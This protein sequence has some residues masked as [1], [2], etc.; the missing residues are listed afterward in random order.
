MIGLIYLKELMLKKPKINASAL[1]MITGIFLRL[2]S[3]RTM[4]C[5]SW[6]IAKHYEF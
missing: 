2:V 1:F 4:Q 3:A 6:F 5:L